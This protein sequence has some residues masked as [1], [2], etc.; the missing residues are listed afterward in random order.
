MKVLAE[1]AQITHFS[2]A[3][4]WVALI[5]A[6]IRRDYIRPNCIAPK[7]LLFVIIT[8]RS[9]CMI[10]SIRRYLQSPKTD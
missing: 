3:I 7:C 6:F 2:Q 9:Q 10:M 8:Y 5:V 4:E 1:D